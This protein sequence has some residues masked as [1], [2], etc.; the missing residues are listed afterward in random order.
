MRVLAANTLIE[1]IMMSIKENDISFTD[2]VFIVNKLF[3]IS[4]FSSP[5][6][7]VDGTII[8]LKCFDFFY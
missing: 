6:R 5:R 2:A 3:S 4:T 1:E 8:T 7:F